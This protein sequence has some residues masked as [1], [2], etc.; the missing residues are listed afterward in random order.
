MNAAAAR[1]LACLCCLALPMPGIGAQASEP[2]LA[3]GV[4]PPADARASLPAA[5]PLRREPVTAL[6]NAPWLGACGT[7]AVFA[8]GG[9]LLVGRRRKWAWLRLRGERPQGARDLVRLAS[10]PLTA[11]ASLHAIRWHGEDLLLGCTPQQVTLLAR[12]PAPAPLEEA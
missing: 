7:L 12:H 11:Q 1:L 3:A 6:P 2:S 4:A 5:L 9:T 10:Q 8:V